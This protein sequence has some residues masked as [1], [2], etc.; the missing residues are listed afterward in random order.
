MQPLRFAHKGTKAIMSK[1]LLHRPRHNL[2]RSSPCDFT[3][4]TAAGSWQSRCH[5]RCP[6]S[7][8][9]QNKKQTWFLLKGHELLYEYTYTSVILG[10]LCGLRISPASS[11]AFQQTRPLF[12]LQW[13][14]LDLSISPWL[15]KNLVFLIALL[16]DYS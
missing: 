1:V 12:G 2:A 14:L 15:S 13:L 8:T 7:K 4:S 5:V 6:G 11:C 3:E 10:N 9:K 16:S